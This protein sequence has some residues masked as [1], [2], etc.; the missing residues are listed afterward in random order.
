MKIAA[1]NVCLEVRLSFFAHLRSLAENNLNDNKLRL[2]TIE[3]IGE[4][5]L[6]QRL[7]R[8]KELS[9]FMETLKVMGL[10]ASQKNRYRIGQLSIEM[11]PTYYNHAAYQ[12]Y[13]G[14]FEAQGWL[15][16][17]VARDNGSDEVGTDDQLSITGK[18]SSEESN[19]N[20]KPQPTLMPLHPAS[21]S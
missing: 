1:C 4:T 6:H 13:H 8:H 11:D 15:E 16:P 5:D 7:D 18:L 20:P 2:W 3:A 17:P 14:W 10:S 21:G 12:K 19:V 9:E